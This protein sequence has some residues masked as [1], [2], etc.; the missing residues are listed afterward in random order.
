MRFK[1]YL[2]KAWQNMKANPAETAFK[3]IGTVT[4]GASA[5]LCGKRKAKSLLWVVGSEFA[6]LM[7]K[8]AYD[9]YVRKDKKDEEVT[10]N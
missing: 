9:K 8:D 10:E 3:V 5:V 6:I 2:E 7:V 4:V 1:G